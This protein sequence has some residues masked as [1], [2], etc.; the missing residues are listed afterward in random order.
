[1]ITVIN[2]NHKKMTVA[3]QSD[4]KRERLKESMHNTAIQYVACKAST[5]N[6]DY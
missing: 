3:D 4:M 5:F 6:P 2:T 1:M